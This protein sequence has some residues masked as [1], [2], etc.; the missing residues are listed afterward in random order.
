MQQLKSVIQC[1][2]NED[3]AQAKEKLREY[4]I[5]KTKEQIGGLT[6]AKSDSVNKEAFFQK[7]LAAVFVNV[8]KEVKKHRD[9]I[10][11]FWRDFAEDAVGNAIDRLE[12][13]GEELPSNLDSIISKLERSGTALEK[14]FKEKYG[15]SSK[16]WVEDSAKSDFSK[17]SASEQALYKKLSYELNTTFG[18]AEVAA[19]NLKMYKFSPKTLYVDAFGA[20]FYASDDFFKS[21]GMSM[22]EVIATLEKHGAKLSK[23]PAR[24]RGTP[25]AY[26]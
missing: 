11:S 17:L 10:P 21:V 4:I 18:P 6:E 25:G 24:I 15:V 5:E 12:D 13:Q 20:E 14:M 26:D 19:G 1:L 16:K 8:E 9:S 7:A 22:A 2:I 23:Q 3:E